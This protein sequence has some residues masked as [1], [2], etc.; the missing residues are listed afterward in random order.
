MFL[1]WPVLESKSTNIGLLIAV[2]VL[3]IKPKGN[4][5]LIITLLKQQ[6]RSFFF[7]N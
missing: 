7:W 3:S 5:R 2:Y 6:Y 1:K 4:A